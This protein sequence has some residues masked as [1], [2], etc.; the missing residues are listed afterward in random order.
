MRVVRRR[1]AGV[2]VPRVVARALSRVTHRLFAR[3]CRVV[4][5]VRARRERCFMF[6]TRIATHRHALPAR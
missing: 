6:V 1:L 5:V 2:F 3:H 4:R